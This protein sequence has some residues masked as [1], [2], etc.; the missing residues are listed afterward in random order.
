MLKLIKINRKVLIYLT[1]YF[2]NNLKY[3]QK[4]KKISYMIDKYKDTLYLSEI[5]QLY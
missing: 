5:I 1:I 4:I 3:L 2:I